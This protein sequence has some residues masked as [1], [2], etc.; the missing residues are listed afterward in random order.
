MVESVLFNDIIL[1]IALIIMVYIGVVRDAESLLKIYVWIAAL[2]LLS[3]MYWLWL[4]LPKTC[5]GLKPEYQ[6]KQWV[7]TAFP[8]LFAG[9]AQVVLHRT[10]VLVLGYLGNMEATGI[11]SLADRIAIL[12]TFVMTSVNAIGAPMLSA[13]FYRDDIKEFRVIFFKTLKWSSIGALVPFCCMLFFPEFLLGFFGEE[14]VAGKLVLQILAVGHFYNAATGLV[15]SA[16]SMTGRERIF[17]KITLFIS[18][19]N[20]IACYACA[21]IWGGV[22][23]AIVYSS[24]IIIFNTL[25]LIIVAMEFKIGAHKD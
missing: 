8:L 25:L 17:G 13:A 21:K 10:S 18:V 22:G 2:I 16:L 12:I 9:V 24:S 3:G 14:F 20:L 15:G 6:T 19:F 7:K 1:P 11:F 5:K 23:A 4:R